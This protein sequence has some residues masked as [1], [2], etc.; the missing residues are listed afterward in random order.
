MGIRVD[1]NMKPYIPSEK[2]EEAIILWVV[3]VVEMFC[4]EYNILPNYCV[5]IGK[6]GAWL[7]K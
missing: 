5:N 7:Y 1:I 4:L 2:V 6:D 3:M